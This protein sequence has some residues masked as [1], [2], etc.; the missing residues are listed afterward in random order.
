MRLSFLLIILSVLLFS[1][2]M[3]TSVGVVPDELNISNLSLSEDGSLEVA[4]QDYT[5]EAF[6][7]FLTMQEANTT[8][9]IK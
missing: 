6:S 8:L 9:V 7:F 4:E 1:G 2:C 3:T 5:V